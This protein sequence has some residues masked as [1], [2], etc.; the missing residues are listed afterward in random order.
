MIEVPTVDMYYVRVYYLCM[1]DVCYTLCTT[2]NVLWKVYVLYTEVYTMHST[3]KAQLVILPVIKYHNKVVY[4]IWFRNVYTIL[5]M[6]I[7][8]TGTTLS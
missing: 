8:F 5:V 1:H 4:Y 6:C 2:H 7:L 3:H